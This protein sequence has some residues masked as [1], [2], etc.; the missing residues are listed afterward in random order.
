MIFGLPVQWYF[1]MDSGGVSHFP[2]WGTCAV[3]QAKHQ[4]QMLGVT[5]SLISI[6]PVRKTAQTV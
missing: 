1:K 6:F 5:K 2:E 3:L 4:P